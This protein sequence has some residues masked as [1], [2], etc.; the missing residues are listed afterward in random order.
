MTFYDGST[1]LGTIDLNGSGQAM[2]TKTWTTAGT[3][4]IKVKYNGDSNFNSVTSGV[5]T[6]TVT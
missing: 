1:V 3:H 4:K 5:F 6:E 2:L